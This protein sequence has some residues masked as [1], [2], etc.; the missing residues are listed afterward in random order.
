MAVV[1]LDRGRLRALE[2]RG[3]AGG[4]VDG[5]GAVLEAAKAVRVG[6]GEAL[7]EAT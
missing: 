4:Q 1:D 3:L 5:E 2:G 6:I 7:G